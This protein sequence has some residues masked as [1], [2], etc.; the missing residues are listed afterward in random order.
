MSPSAVVELA[1]WDDEMS[2]FCR[3]IVVRPIETAPPQ[4]M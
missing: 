2:A 4:A 1:R 3:T